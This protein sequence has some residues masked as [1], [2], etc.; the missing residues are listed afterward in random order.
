MK[1]NSDLPSLAGA[2]HWYNGQYRP[3]E[4][5]GAPVLVHF[6]SVSCGVCSEQMPEVARWRNNYTPRGLRMVAVHQPR[7]EKD[8]DL[9]RVE[10]AVRGY[11]LT[12]LV[13]V[14]NDY[15]VVDAFENK[16]VPAF[17]VF[18]AEGHLRLFQAGEKGLPMVVKAIERVL[19]RPA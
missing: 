1:I 12:Q 17:Y 14:D 3:E 6:W 19:T 18:D 16:Y 2:A 10:E 13:A 15:S 9:A 5:Q 4:L 8:M 11:G 7:S